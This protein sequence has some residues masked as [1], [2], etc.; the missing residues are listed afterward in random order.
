MKKLPIGIQDFRKLR[1]NNYLYVDKTELIY[2]LAKTGG[3]YFLSRPRRFGKS[4]LVSTM[5]ALFSGEK[6]LFKGLWIEDKW[7]WEKKN[8]VIHLS[9]SRLDYKKDSLEN[10][11]LAWLDKEAERHGI[12]LSGKTVKQKFTEFIPLLAQQGK[13]VFL[14]DEYDKPII[15]FIES[16]EGVNENREVLRSLYS[17]IKDLDPYFKLVF[18]TGV[19]KFS[20]V[21]LFSDL[22]NLEDITLDAHFNALCG[23]TQAELVHYFKDRIAGHSE[24]S[25]LPVEKLLEQIK[26]WY[27]GYNWT[28]KERLYNPFSILNYIKKGQFHNFWFS[29]G[30]PTFLIT[31][32]QKNYYFQLD[33]EMVGSTLLDFFDIEAPDYRSLL[34]Q[35]GYLTIKEQVEY[36]VFL[37]GYPNKEVKDSLMQ[38]LL[39]AYIYKSRGDAA[40]AV[41]KLRRALEK[42]DTSLFISIL[43]GLFASIPEKIFRQRNEAAYHAIVFISLSLLG[44]YIDSEVSVGD[45]IVDAVIKTDSRIYVVEFKYDKTPEE[46]IQQIREKNYAEPFRHDGRE[47]VLLGVAFGKEEKGVSGWKEEKLS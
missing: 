28:G 42:G 21:S 16:L 1:E 36:N 14:V 27:N 8:P 18:L 33:D 12:K 13:V 23:Y 29:T 31:L 6:E 19:S 41:L 26:S 40:P 25:G 15:D 38:Y 35:T 45:G 37:L 43:N 3:Y 11:L 24:V 2:Q 9:F 20:K 47:I 4:L 34:F 32:L 39:G 30:T 7:N 44:F 17:G 22:N 46:A 5:K 10:A